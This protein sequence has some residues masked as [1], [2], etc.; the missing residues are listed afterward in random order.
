MRH[1]LAGCV[2]SGLGINIELYIILT[3]CCAVQF[4]YLVTGGAGFIGSAVVPKIIFETDHRV[5]VLDKLTYAGN[6]KSLGSILLQIRSSCSGRPIFATAASSPRSSPNSEPDCIL[7]LAAE[8][9]HVDRS[10][11][12]RLAQRNV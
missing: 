7:H 1:D 10:A 8:E 11:S 12:H 6:L 4:R 2:A 5:C 9:S 3:W